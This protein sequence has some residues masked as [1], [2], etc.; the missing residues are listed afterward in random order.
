MHIE[1]NHQKVE[2][3]DSGHYDKDE[4][5]DIE[6]HS[7]F[8]DSVSTESVSDI[9]EDKEEESVPQDLSMISHRENQN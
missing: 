2:G 9:A 4:S 1:Q 5:T 6:Q 7:V 3:G 8:N